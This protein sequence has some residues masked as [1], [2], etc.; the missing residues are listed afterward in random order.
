MVLKPLKP[1]CVEVFIEYP[2]LGRFVIRDM[3][4]TVAVGVVKSV[5]SYVDAAP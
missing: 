2:P 1:L 3:L 4:I 5:E